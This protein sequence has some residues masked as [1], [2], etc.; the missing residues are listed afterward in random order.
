MKTIL[1]VPMR[2]VSG[3]K[4]CLLLL[5]VVPALSQTTATPK[6]DAEIT[7][8]DREAAALF[9]QQNLLAAL[10]LYQ[11]LHQQ[12]PTS[13]LYREQLAL[14]LLAK[15]ATVPEQEAIKLRQQA[16]ALLL[17]AKAAGDN[18]NLLNILLEK[19]G[20]Q[21]GATPTTQQSPARETLA[22]AEKAFSSGDLPGSLVLYKQASEED[23]KLYDAP[24]FAGDA[25]YKQNHYDEAG[26]WYAKAITIDPNRETAYR[27]WGDV[28][29]HKGDQKQAQ[30]KFI[31]A[32]IAEPYTKAPWLG[33]QQWANTIHAKLI[34][35]QIALP[36]LPVPDAKGNVNVSIDASTLGSPASSAWLIYQ[37]NPT[38]WRKTEFHKHYPQ[39]NDY[40]HSLAEEAEG[41]R[42]VIAVVHE[43]KIPEDKLDVTLK[44][45]L[46]LDKDGVLECWILLNHADAGIA[47]DYAA[48]RS[49]HRELLHAYMDKYLVHF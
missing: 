24:L 43:Q 31:D 17:E 48:Y 36:A 10:P 18:S 22:K 44:T 2:V 4:L 27:Y 21:P 46:T 26:A 1:G 34:F 49:T 32:V 9:Q 5:S 7:R 40:R 33:L 29:M 3:L 47:Q 19:M 13:N 14:C 23:P 6:T 37:M 39:E 15:E 41:L 28:L 45:L 11:D 12:R 38:L 30:S 42:S 35:P 25:E 8:E 20:N 16:R